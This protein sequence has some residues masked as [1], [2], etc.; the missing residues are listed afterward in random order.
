MKRKRIAVTKL[1]DPHESIERL[2]TYFAKIL[3]S[4]RI[5]RLGKK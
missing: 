5:K 1:G 3:E 2:N 4:K